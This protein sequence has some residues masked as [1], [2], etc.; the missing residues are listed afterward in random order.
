ME[1]RRRRHVAVSVLLAG[2]LVA[3]GCARDDSRQNKDEPTS[4][5]TSSGGVRI[6][7]EAPRSGASVT[8]PLEVAGRA[9][10]SWSFE[11]DFPVE[12]LDADRRTVAEGYATM[13]G[14]WMT[15]KDVD[16]AGTIEFAQPR[17]ASGF[18]VLRKANPS[19]LRKHDDAVEIPVRFAR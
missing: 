17:T 1:G 5:Y 3:V 15:E 9:P 2:A 11:A 13:K 12:I 18:L 14:D 8:S 7:V 6:T 19:G 16:F 10:G 4:E